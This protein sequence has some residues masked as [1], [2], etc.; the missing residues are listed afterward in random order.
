M[1]KSK[2]SYSGSVIVDFIS[3][4]FS[5]AYVFLPLNAYFTHL[6]D[7]N[8]FLLLAATMIFLIGIFCMAF[9]RWTEKSEAW[10]KNCTVVFSTYEKAKA[11]VA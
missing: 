2:K 11:R 6:P 7:L 5:L 9:G 3:I 1:K 4:I 8:P 10:F